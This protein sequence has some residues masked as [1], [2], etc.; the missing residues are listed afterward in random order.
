MLQRILPYIALL[1]ILSASSLAGA[2]DWSQLK[3]GMS[4][5]E[6]TERLGLPLIK[7]IGG[8]FELWIYDNNAEAVFYG[9]PLVGWTTPTKGTVAGQAVDVWQHKS[10]AP[11]APLFILPRSPAPV[12]RIDRRRDDG[13]YSSPFYRLRN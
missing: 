5:D 6:A 12:K 9:G 2:E 4:T 1:L 13:V 10:G 3:I 7:T 11:I 8:G